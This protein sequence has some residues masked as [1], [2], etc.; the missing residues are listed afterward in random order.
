M[1][2]SNFNF[3]QEELY[4]KSVQTV[5]LMNR[6]KEI[7]SK[8][9]VNQSKIDEFLTKA[10][11]FAQCSFDNE[12]LGVQMFKT[13]AKNR[14]VSELKSAVSDLMLKVEMSATRN[15][16]MY[17]QFRNVSLAE[18]SNTELVFQ[19]RCTANIGLKY[20]AQLTD[21]GV[22]LEEIQKINTLVNQLTDSL[23]EQNVAIV[24]RNIATRARAEKTNELFGLLSTYRNLGR[25]MWLNSDIS[26]SN[27]YVMSSGGSSNTENEPVTDTGNPLVVE[28]DNG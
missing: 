11:A 18:L 20:L 22:T 15:S 25:K 6:D 28:T 13:E 7:F 14:K 16:I 23:N 8:Y 2:N 21:F 27:D 1:T 3:S 19:G 24:E 26:R 4:Q 12:F 5:S 9:G 17:A 10:T